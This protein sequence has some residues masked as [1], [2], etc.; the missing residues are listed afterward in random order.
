MS[1]NSNSNRKCDVLL[2]DIRVDIVQVL[3]KVIALEGV[4]DTRAR[5]LIF[6]IL[7]SLSG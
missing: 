4:F 2:E 7:R 1:R 6:R 5:I 3:L